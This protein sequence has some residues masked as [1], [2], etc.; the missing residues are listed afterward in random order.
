MAV[1]SEHTVSALEIQAGR[2][3]TKE[4]S[5]ASGLQVDVGK[6]PAADSGHASGSATESLSHAGGWSKRAKK[7]QRQAGFC[8]RNAPSLLSRSDN[9]LDLEESVMH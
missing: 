3:L 5:H 6:A 1:I 4:E 9:S 7:L 2:D 8:V